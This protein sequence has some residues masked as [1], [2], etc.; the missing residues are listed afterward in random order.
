MLFLGLPMWLSAKEYACQCR[1]FEFDP[2]VGK[3]SWRRQWQPTPAF[4]PGEP[5]GEGSLMGYSLQ[6]HKESDTTEQ[7][8]NRQT[9]ML[10]I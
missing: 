7:L 9:T 2:W 10:F 1:R 6:G 5:H 3:A 8:N 4:L